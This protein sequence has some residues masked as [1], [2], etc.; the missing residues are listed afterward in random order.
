MAARGGLRRVNWRWSRPPRSVSPNSNAWPARPR[1][2]L[3]RHILGPAS[4]RALC[5][6]PSGAATCAQRRVPSPATPSVSVFP[7]KTDS[8]LLLGPTRQVARIVTE[9]DFAAKERGV[10]FS[11]LIL[12]QVFSESMP[13]EVVERVRRE[14]RTTAAKEIMIT[15]VITAAEETPR[16][17]WQG[18]C[19]V[20]TSIISRC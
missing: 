3:S 18:R 8:K 7:L 10:P 6:V 17:R 16:R 5:S 14:A 11:L 12:P 1:R 15:E 9:T 2:A 13:R 4:L 20:T 19:S